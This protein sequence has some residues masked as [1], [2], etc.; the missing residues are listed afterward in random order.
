MSFEDG[1][2]SARRD[3][4]PRLDVQD[5]KIREQMANADNGKNVEPRPT[6][7]S[8]KSSNTRITGGI[9]GER[10][11]DNSVNAK[12][13]SNSLLGLKMSNSKRSVPSIS[14]PTGRV[15]AGSSGSQTPKSPTA[16]RSPKSPKQDSKDGTEGCRQDYFERQATTNLSSGSNSPFTR[17]NSLAPLNYQQKREGLKKQYLNL[18]LIKTKIEKD[19]IIVTKD[20]ARQGLSSEIESINFKPIID[21]SVLNSYDKLKENLYIPTFQVLKY[22][23]FLNIL[24]DHHRNDPVS[25]ANVR[26]HSLVN[27][28]TSYRLNQHIK[29]G[30]DTRKHD[31]RFYESLLGYELLCCRTIFRELIR[32][33]TS[34]NDDTTTIMNCEE[35]VQLNLSNYARFVLGLPDELPV[36]FEQLDDFQ[37]THFRYKD[38]FKKIGHGLYL[39][40]KEVAGD[41]VSAFK[42]SGEYVLQAMRKV[43]YEYILLEKYLIHILTKLGN[44]SLI[45][46]RNLKYLFD[47][48]ID[49]MANETNESVKVLHYNT[50]YS[51]QYAWYLSI[52]VPFVR[53]FEMNIHSENPKL[54]NNFDAY[55]KKVMETEKTAF[56][57]LD[58]EIHDT[59]FKHLGLTDYSKY[60]GLNPKKL[61]ELAKRIDNSQ[62]ANKDSSSFTHKPKNFEYYTSPLYTVESETFSLIQSRDLPLEL[63][64]DN[65]ATILREFHRILQEDGIL[66]IP[67]IQLSRDS[68]AGEFNESDFP[69]CEGFMN[70]DLT[71]KFKIIPD[72]VKTV[73]CELNAIFGNGNVKYTQATLNC[74]GEINN[75][76]GKHVCFQLFEMFDRLDDYCAKFDNPDEISVNINDE[77][78]YFY[79]YIRAQK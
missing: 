72:F 33:E 20:S 23:N 7:R 43:S 4:I 11:R 10:R 13:L 26:H 2:T 31:L 63:T 45:E 67:V 70:V 6:L 73:L 36:P 21:L 38:L 9:S 76:V 18:N 75:Y 17:R 79:I 47:T 71:K 78:L 77:G 41:E 15:S 68:I 24:S 49:R 37:K 58:T 42:D 50:Y 55:Q 51:S 48:Y 46:S 14:G 3:L 66:E 35:L 44:N 29:N 19:T 32:L 60:R 52:T 30:F 39:L 12:E 59:Y 16:P 64:P 56:T 53:V 74:I 8:N 25:F 54:V 69:K 22:H 61:V 62:N 40:N 57:E 34:K 5:E 65:Y 27:F 28:I 1:H